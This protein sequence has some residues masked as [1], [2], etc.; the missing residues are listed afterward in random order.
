MSKTTTTDPYL[1]ACEALG[2]KPKPPLKDRSDKD[3]VSIDAYRRLI[4]C[5]RAKNMVDGKIWTPVYDGSEWHYW[6]YFKPK[7][8]GLGFTGTRYDDWHTSTI[9]GSRLEYRSRS[10]A[11]EGAREFEALYN[12]F[13]TV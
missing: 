9:V 4:V 10:L 1:K 3:E 6:P 2:I 8:T 5:I 12:D 13:L 11:E 7:S